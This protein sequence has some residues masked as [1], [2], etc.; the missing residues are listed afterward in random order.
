MLDALWPTDKVPGAV[1][2]STRDR[3][4]IIAELKAEVAQLRY[5]LTQRPTIDEMRRLD[6]ADHRVQRIITDVDTYNLFR[7]CLHPDSRG[8]VSSE[9]LH[10]AWLAFRNLEALTYDQ[11]KL[12]PPLPRD[13]NE[14]LAR[15]YNNMARKAK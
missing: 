11:T 4:A 1:R 2:R 14:L 15:R 12:P 13:L 5:E 7:R 10:D 8:S 9:I 3:D 6:A